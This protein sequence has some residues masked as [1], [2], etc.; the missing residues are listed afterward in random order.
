MF[1]YQRI[2]VLNGKRKMDKRKTIEV[3][4]AVV[5]VTTRRFTLAFIYLCSHFISILYYI[6]CNYV[7]PSHFERVEKWIRV[8]FSPFDEYIFLKKWAR[9]T[10]L[11]GF[12]F[13]TKDDFSHWS[14]YMGSARWARTHLRKPLPIYCIERWTCKSIGPNWSYVWTTDRSA[15]LFFW[16]VTIFLVPVNSLYHVL[17]LMSHDFHFY[18]PDDCR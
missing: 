10:C 7:L 17:P 8:Y 18:P 12:R 6:K 9:E 5:M 15:L 13:R 16:I 1:A 4:S 14:I 2:I 11:I 3:W